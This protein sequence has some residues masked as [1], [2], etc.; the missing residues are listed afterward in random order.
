MKRT[1]AGIIF[2]LG[3]WALAGLGGCASD[4]P[5][6]ESF[7]DCLYGAPE[8]I[9]DASVPGVSQHQF[10]LLSA[11]SMESFVLNHSTFVQIEQTGCDQI[12]QEF[13][14]SWEAANRKEDWALQA[15]Q[16]Y[17]ELGELGA[18]YLSFKAISEV[19]QARREKLHPRGEAISLQPGLSFRIT[20][21]EEGQQSKLVT[22]LYETAPGG[23]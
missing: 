8:P 21:A 10:E 22:V 9:F 1:L 2:S 6:H 4:P 3:L 17:R 18:P 5:P 16:K 11:K 14:F 20:A 13:T 19:L 15:I 23:E 7:E 12:R